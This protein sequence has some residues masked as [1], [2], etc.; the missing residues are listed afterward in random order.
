MVPSSVSSILASAS[1]VGFSGSR[2]LAGRE[3]LASACVS[4]ATLL[5][6]RSSCSFAVGCA[7]GVDAFFRGYFPSASVFRVS[8][9]SRGAF[10][11]RSVSFVQSL[12]AS[13]G[14]LVSFPSG[15]C[16]V[17]LLPST[18]SSRCFSG[19]GSGTW[20]SLAFAVG[21]GVRCFVFAP[22]G[23]PSGWGFAPCGGGW[24]S[25]AP[26]GSQLGLF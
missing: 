2:S 25:F 11:A 10:A 15:A 22:F 21:R 16:P 4:V 5:A 17:G 14:V 24:F 18:S 9:S 19:F 8:G 23:V 1:L 26:S 12:A 3:S 13:S 6:A 7:A 20:A